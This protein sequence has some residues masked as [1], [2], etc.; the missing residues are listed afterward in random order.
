M[1][2]LSMGGALCAALFLAGCGVVTTPTE[3]CEDLTEVST[4]RMFECGI[5]GQ[6]QLYTGDGV[7][8]TCDD[9]NAVTSWDLLFDECF[10]WWEESSC[11]RIAGTIISTGGQ[12]GFCQVFQYA[13]PAR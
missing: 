6:L 12:P 9:V 2:R 13:V 10:P 4:R 11:E 8:V 3:A 5:P 1:V 7:P